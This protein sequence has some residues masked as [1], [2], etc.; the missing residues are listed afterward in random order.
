VKIPESLQLAI[1]AIQLALSV[2][3]LVALVRWARLQQRINRAVFDR[4]R[5]IELAELRKAKERGEELQEP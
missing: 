4:L 2:T 1:S 3:L 5:E